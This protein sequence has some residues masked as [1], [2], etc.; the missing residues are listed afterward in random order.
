M[1]HD[2]EQ[3]HAL[4]PTAAS[5]AQRQH[6]NAKKFVPFR[7]VDGDSDSPVLVLRQLLERRSYPRFVP[8][9]SSFP[10]IQ[11]IEQLKI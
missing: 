9:M 10:Y 11:A 2:F 3:Q 1:I 6:A 7:L 4:E 8:Y 5:F